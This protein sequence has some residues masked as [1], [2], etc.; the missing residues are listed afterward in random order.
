MWKE[1]ITIVDR[2]ENLINGVLSIL[3]ELVVHK[4]RSP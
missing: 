2:H 4:V 3:T 1:V